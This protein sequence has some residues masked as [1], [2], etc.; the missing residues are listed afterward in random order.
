MSKLWG[1]RFTG[2]TD[3]V[4]EQFNLSLDVDKVMWEADLDGSI[5]YS[6][7]LERAQVCDATHADEHAATV[8]ACA[9]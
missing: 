1:G 6:R 9:G 3:P 5:A 8:C 7:A 4:M 2:K